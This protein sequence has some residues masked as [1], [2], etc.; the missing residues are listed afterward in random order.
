MKLPVCIA[1]AS[2]LIH[3]QREKDKKQKLIKTEAGKNFGLQSV[4]MAAWHRRRKDGLFK[5]T[6]QI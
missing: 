1:Q 4:I 3:L 5:Q 2:N 6:L